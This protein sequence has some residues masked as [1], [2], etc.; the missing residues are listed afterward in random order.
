MFN[1]CTIGEDFN[2]SRGIYRHP[3]DRHRRSP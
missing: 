1:L 3:L 2:P